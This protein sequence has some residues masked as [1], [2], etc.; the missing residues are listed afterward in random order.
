MLH[1]RAMDQRRE[2]AMLGWKMLTTSRIGVLLLLLLLQLSGAKGSAAFVSYPTSHRHRIPELQWELD[3]SHEKP[4]EQRG[5]PD[6][7]DGQRLFL[8]AGCLATASLVLVGA[9]SAWAVD[10]PVDFAH[11][12]IPSTMNSADP[13]YFIAGGLCAAASHGVTTPSKL[14]AS[15]KCR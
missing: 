10:H 6:K 2:G 15:E 12:R 3:L 7:T 14:L 13:R 1:E 4:A 9:H 5:D 11:L 8:A